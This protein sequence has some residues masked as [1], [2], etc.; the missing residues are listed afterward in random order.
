MG[1]AESASF[2]KKKI[3]GNYGFSGEGKLHLMIFHE[4]CSLSFQVGVKSDSTLYRSSS[5]VFSS[6]PDF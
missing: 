5:I 6:K 4:K 1:F 3:V 2:E